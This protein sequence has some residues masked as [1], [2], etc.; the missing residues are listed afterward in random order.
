[1]PFTYVTKAFCH[2]QPHLK[3]WLSNLDIEIQGLVCVFLVANIEK[4]VEIV[5]YRFLVVEEAHECGLHLHDGQ[6][7]S[8]RV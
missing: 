5:L 2:A 8:L 1:M 6:L 3:L 4:P 7:E